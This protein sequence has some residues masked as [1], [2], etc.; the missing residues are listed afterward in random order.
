MVCSSEPAPR[1]GLAGLGGN[2]GNGVVVGRSMGLIYPGGYG[3]LV[4][5][6]VAFGSKVGSGSSGINSIESSSLGNAAG[7][8]ANRGTRPINNSAAMP[9]I[10]LKFTIA[11]SFLL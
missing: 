8:Q 2:V 3:V 7:P 5:C 9:R 11:Y 1:G 10:F 6:S 4:G